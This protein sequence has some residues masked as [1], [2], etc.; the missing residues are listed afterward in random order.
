LVDVF[1]EAHTV[2]PAQ[3]ALDLDSTDLP[4]Y[5]PQEQRFFHGYYDEYCYVPLY[6]PA[7]EHLLC[8]RLRPCNQNGPTGCVGKARATVERMRQAWPTARII[9]RGD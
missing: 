5:D 3:I 4:L 8:A 6:M 9:V 2:A 7:G 1:L